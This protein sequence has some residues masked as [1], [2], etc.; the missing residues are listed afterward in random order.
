MRLAYTAL[1][2]LVACDQLGA[3]PDAPPGDQIDAARTAIPDM[4][5]KWVGSGISMMVV[6]SKTLAETPTVTYD[7]YHDTTTVAPLQVG[8]AGNWQYYHMTATVPIAGNDAE[9]QTGTIPNSAD[10][11]GALITGF[12]IT[13]MDIDA[14]N[15]A[16]SGAAALFASLDSYTFRTNETR[17]A[18][19]ADVATFAS[20]HQVTTALGGPDGSIWVTAEQAVGDTASYQTTVVDATLATLQSQA[21]SLASG[22]YVITAAGILGN[23]NQI[24]LVGTKPPGGP[25]SFS[26]MS[27]TGAGQTANV[28]SALA[29]GYNIVANV[30]D[31]ATGA[32]VILEK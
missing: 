29:A 7:R 18:L 6:E 17:A 14:T 25:S 21:Q 24:V 10:V 1:L 22:G 15:Y 23:P 4:R 31:P 19:T 20:N 28:D 9:V 27:V 3:T 13:S 30:Y 2:A 32:H 26:I 16:I 8:G 5:F 12:T 11:A